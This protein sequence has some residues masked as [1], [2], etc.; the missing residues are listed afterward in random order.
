MLFESLN[1]GF[2]SFSG[3]PDMLVVAKNVGPRFYYT[4]E[5]MSVSSWKS[6]WLCICLHMYLC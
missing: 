6:V 1:E 4:V 3:L 5:N 2:V